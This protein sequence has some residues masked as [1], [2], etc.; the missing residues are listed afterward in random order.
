M[1]YLDTRSGSKD[2]S[3]CDQKVIKKSTPNAYKN[4]KTKKVKAWTEKPVNVRNEM[5]GVSTLGDVDMK[6]CQTGAKD[7]ATIKRIEATK[8]LN[9]VV[10]TKE[11]RGSRVNPNTSVAINPSKSAFSIYDDCNMNIYGI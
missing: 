10:S 2:C 6:G 8:S 4:Y 11:S 3:A 7:R 9:S 1:G 5:I